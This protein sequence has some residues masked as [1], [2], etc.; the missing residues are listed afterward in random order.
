M[1]RER[2][3]GALAAA[4]GAL[5]FVFAVAQSLKQDFAKQVVKVEVPKVETPKASVLRGPV[6]RD[7]TP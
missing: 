5:V 4:M 1:D 3:A 2:L 6:V 7:I